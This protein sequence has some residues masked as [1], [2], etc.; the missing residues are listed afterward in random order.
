MDDLQLIPATIDDLRTIT[1]LATTHDPDDPPDPELVRFS[2]LSPPAGDTI[3][4]TLARVSGSTV[5]YFAAGHG[6]GQGSFGWIRPV[7]PPEHWTDDRF[8][9]L[10]GAAE[11]W[12][13]AE[14]MEI[15]VARVRER[16]RS[17]VLL[18]Q[19]LAYSEVRRQK[20]WEL[21]LVTHRSQLRAA[22]ERSRGRM[23]KLGIELLTL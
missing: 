17:E 5:G 6:E 21:D 10:V 15:S 23:N 12:Q 3:V 20:N 19:S 13:R 16:F 14:G 22:A 11:D 7:L 9:Q 8:L 2:W 1:A 18:L 4:R